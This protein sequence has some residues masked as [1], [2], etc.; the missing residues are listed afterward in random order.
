MDKCYLD[1]AVKIKRIMSNKT[2][3]L[4]RQCGLS[5]EKR[6]KANACCAKQKRLMNKSGQPQQQWRNASH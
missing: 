3:F 5:H 2:V 1:G 6:N 4:C